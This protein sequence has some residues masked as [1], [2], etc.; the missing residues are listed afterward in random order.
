MDIDDE[1]WEVK[2]NGTECSSIG[3]GFRDGYFN[4]ECTHEYNLTGK[5]CEKDCPFNK[6]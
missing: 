1:I 4:D 3:C 2:V 5:C 6:E